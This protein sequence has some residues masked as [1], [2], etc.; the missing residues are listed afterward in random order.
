MEITLKVVSIFNPYSTLS[1]NPASLSQKPNNNLCHL[2]I[3][4]GNTSSFVSNADHNFFFSVA[5]NIQLH[6]LW[7]H[8]KHKNQS[9]LQYI[10]FFN[11]LKKIGGHGTEFSIKLHPI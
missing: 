5:L 4:Y 7:F 8:I 9:A 6:C 2:L 11:T 10:I 1:C 3:Y